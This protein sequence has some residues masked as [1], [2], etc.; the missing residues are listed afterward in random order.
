[1][2][3]LDY[4]DRVGERRLER[5]RIQ[6]PRP[7]DTRMLVGCLFFLGYYVLV[8][9]LRR[10]APMSPQNL[11]LVSD[12]MLVLGPVIGVI[13][14]ALFRSDARD[15]IAAANTGVA[16]R[17]I[18]KQADANKATADSIPNASGGAPEAA[19]RVADAA[20]DEAGRINREVQP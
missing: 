5:W 2:K 10:G 4:L 15:E 3:L 13:A 18:G 8:Y 17:S 16:F 11:S 7:R 1:M 14:Q 19:D 6:P 20:A 12:A 9:S